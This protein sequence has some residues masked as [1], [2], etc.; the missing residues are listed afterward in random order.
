MFCLEFD[1]RKI[2]PLECDFDPQ[3]FGTHLDKEQLSDE[4]FLATAVRMID[5]DMVDQTLFF[6]INGVSHGH[7]VL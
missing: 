4:E 6:Y 2:L 5:Q 7:R 1:I 3:I